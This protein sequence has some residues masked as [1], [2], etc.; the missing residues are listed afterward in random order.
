MPGYGYA[1]RSRESKKAWSSLT[2]SFFTDNPSSDALKLVLQLVDVRTGPTEDDVLMINWLIEQGV[3]FIVVLTKTDKLSKAQLA[4]ALDELN[5]GP[6]RGTG[7]KILPFSSVTRAGRDE[8]WAE[9]NA[10]LDK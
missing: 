6:F 4:Q 9:I 10:A 2:E 5:N 1:K 8:V 7:I 3:E